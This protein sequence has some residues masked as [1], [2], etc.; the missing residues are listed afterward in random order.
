MNDLAR[1]PVC[2]AALSPGSRFCPACGAPLPVGAPRPGDAPPDDPTTPA[3]PEDATVPTPRTAG[4]S[5][6]GPHGPASGAAP[7]GAG[8]RFTPGQLVRGRYRIVSLL[9]RGG[10]GEVYRADDL[11]LG[12]PVALKFLPPELSADPDR[13]QRFRDEVRIALRVTH[14]NVCRVHDIG[15]ADGQLFLSMEYVDGE[16]LA[17]LLRR[18]GRLPQERAVAVARQIC[19]GLAAA[20]DQGILHRDLKP[21]N[22]ML[23]GRGNVRLTDF[24]LAGLADRIDRR[25]VRAGTPAYMAPEQL[26]GDE[27]S[28]RSDIYALGLVLYEIFTGHRAFTAQSVAELQELHASGPPSRLTSHVADLDPAVERAVMRCLERDPADRPATALQVSAALPGGDPLAAALAAGETPSPE[29]VARVG[30]RGR[31]RP[32]V[33]LALAACGLLLVVGATRWAGS[34]SLVH[35]LPLTRQPAVL[36]D[37]ARSI[38]PALGYTEPAFADPVDRAKG[39]ILWGGVLGEVGADTSGAGWAALRQR[40]DAASFWYRQAPQELTPL[41]EDPPV[42]L[43]G[44]V[45]VTQPIPITAGEVT[46]IIDLAGRLRRLEVMPKRLA[47][48]EA[49]EPDWAPLFA[50]AE[51]DTARFRPAT[52]RYGRFF[53][54]DLRRAWLGTR[55]DA[56][57]ETLRVEAA[58]FEGRPV[59]FNVD[60][61]AGVSA[62]ALD[63]TPQRVGPAEQLSRMLQ[64]GLF[65]VVVA[66]AVWL[67]RENLV[68][69]RADLRGALRFAVLVAGLF[70]AGRILAS[71]TLTGSRVLGE[72]WPLLVGAS[73]LGLV[74]WIG[75]V[76]AEP[77]GRR[78]WPSMFVS[79]SRLLS[80]PQVQ[81]RDPLIGQSVLVGL[82]A[83]AASFLLFGPVRRV[84]MVWREGGG[85]PLLGIDPRLLVGG[86]ESLA[87]V[88]DQA[89]MLVMSFLLIVGLVAVQ[90]GVKRRRLAAAIALVIWTLVGGDTSPWGLAGHLV[91]SAISLW[92]LLRWGVVAMVTGRVVLQICWLARSAD[93]SAWTAQGPLL[94][95]G[96]LM[97]LALYGVWAA[98][99]RGA[100]QR[101]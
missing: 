19:A 48:R 63:P 12:Q 27:V 88:L 85:V 38:L 35:Y 79:S 10:M 83:G 52:P 11:E 4:P 86:R 50:F 28:V 90:Y 60:V 89:F 31:M 7:G 34:M 46:V 91:V 96:L 24:G 9:G 18:I 56:P 76:A 78:V 75:Y 58:A 55:A 92:V 57:Q 80:R 39:F 22:V 14:P 1:C 70:L 94:A 20:H 65:L 87:L 71:H 73:F 93:W 53:T 44:P 59:L 54:P 68:R 43:R 3:R 67:G 81:W 64:P 74:T 95:L 2:Q 15:E 5:T 17:S 61:T 101:S 82:I 26:R 98:T 21:A 33:A 49:N 13:L 23:D 16:D 47:T 99:G 36:E 97:V 69:G 62:L 29:L 42:F 8:P 77:L 25:D 37:R 84:A 32:A 100:S 45:D 72:V 40:P 51:L 30:E 66:M 41:P 6:G